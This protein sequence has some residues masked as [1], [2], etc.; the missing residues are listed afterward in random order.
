MA[1][2]CSTPAFTNALYSMKAPIVSIIIVKIITDLIKT[3]ISK[4]LGIANSAFNTFCRQLDSLL[5]FDSNIKDVNV[6]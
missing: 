4:P 5:L 3:L 1:K 6:M 2:L